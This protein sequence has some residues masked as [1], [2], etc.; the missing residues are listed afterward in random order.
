MWLI[1][2]VWVTKSFHIFI[3][4]EGRTKLHPANHL[5]ADLRGDEKHMPGL[6]LEKETWLR[7][8]V[9]VVPVQM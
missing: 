6:K 7:K 8:E 1:K 2:A 5:G 4:K 9:Y 3:K